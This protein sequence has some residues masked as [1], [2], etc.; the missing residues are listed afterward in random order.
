VT[1]ADAAALGERAEAMIAELGAIS[2]ASGR[3]RAARAR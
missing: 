3:H 2:T 1:A